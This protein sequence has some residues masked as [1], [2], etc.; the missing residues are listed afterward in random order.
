VVVDHVVSQGPDQVSTA[1]DQ[2]PVQ[3]LTTHL[4]AGPPGAPVGSRCPHRDVDDP[5]RDS[6]EDFV[7]AWPDVVPERATCRRDGAMM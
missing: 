3:A 6:P 2:H 7:E 1:G 5:D 4:R